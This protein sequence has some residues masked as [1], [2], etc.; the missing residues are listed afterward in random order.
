MLF[1]APDW[2]HS[3]HSPPSYH[4]QRQQGHTA[5]VSA[6]RDGFLPVPRCKIHCTRDHCQHGHNHLHHVSQ[7][8]SNLV[9]MYNKAY[10]SLRAFS[11]VRW[12]LHQN[13]VPDRGHRFRCRDA[14]V[15]VREC[16]HTAW[17]LHRV[18]ATARTRHGPRQPGAWRESAKGNSS[19][20]CLA[21]SSR[22]RMPSCPAT[23][24][25]GQS[26]SCRVTFH[27]KRYILIRIDTVRTPKVVSQGG[28]VGRCQNGLLILPIRGKTSGFIRV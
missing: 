8:V 22:C 1:N 7:A 20:Q 25:R 24:G 28:K 27:S 16:Y 18:C 3:P 17:K 23:T 19:K 21:P 2:Y 10:G 6:P 13:V 5:G 4:Q 26:T 12:D 15:E 11:G 14:A 9:T